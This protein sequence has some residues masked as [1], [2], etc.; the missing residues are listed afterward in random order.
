[1]FQISSEW[2]SL[3]YLSAKCESRTPA[4]R[5]CTSALSLC[6]I[7]PIV[8]VKFLTCKL[9]KKKNK[10]NSVNKIKFRKFHPNK[11]LSPK[12]S[13]W[14][15]CYMCIKNIYIPVNKKPSLASHIIISQLL[16][17]G[18][19]AI[20]SYLQFFG[21]HAIVIKYIDRFRMLSYYDSIA[22]LHFDAHRRAVLPKNTISTSYKHPILSP[23]LHLLLFVAIYIWEP[24]ALLA[25]HVNVC[26]R[27]QFRAK[28]RFI[29]F[30][31][32]MARN[33]VCLF[34]FDLCILIGKILY[35][36]CFNL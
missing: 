30:Q 6:Y 26:N 2:N 10:K 35:P 14:W 20:F 21:S 17:T 25:N 34:I 12:Q 9:T 27:L 13:D 29:A 31:R 28:R 1:M 7:P 4:I 33:L 16:P 8:S 36:Y 18:V 23:S 24:N 3:F 11:L 32:K 22:T 15:T 5:V 19:I